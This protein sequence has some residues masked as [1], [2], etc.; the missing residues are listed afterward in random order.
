APGLYSVGIGSIPPS[1]HSPATQAPGLAGGHPAWSLLLCQSLMMMMSLLMTQLL[2]VPTDW[3]KPAL[4]VAM[5]TMMLMTMMMVLPF[6]TPASPTQT[7]SQF[8]RLRHQVDELVVLMRDNVV[9]WRKRGTRIKRFHGR[10]DR[11]SKIS[12]AFKVHARGFHKA[13]WWKHNRMKTIVQLE[14]GILFAIVSV[15]LATHAAGSNGL[16]KKATASN[17]SGISKHQDHLVGDSRDGLG[18]P[19]PVRERMD[20]ADKLGLADQ[21]TSQEKLRDSVHDKFVCGE[22]NSNMRGADRLHCL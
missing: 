4:F 3:A 15:T 8:Q 9:V 10:M 19:N 21:N 20:Q 6:E 11:L 18:S 22:T 7:S 17:F 16:T 2:L 1:A 13:I 12:R 14:I 5:M